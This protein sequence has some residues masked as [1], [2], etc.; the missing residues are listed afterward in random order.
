MKETVKSKL[1]RYNYAY[2]EKEHSLDINLG[3]SQYLIVD[4][5]REG[6][7]TFK[8]KLRGWNFITGFFDTNY[9]TAVLYQT[10]GLFFAVIL[11]IVLSS[12][13]ENVKFPFVFLL[14]GM[15]AWIIIW[16]FYYLIKL[17]NMKK[18]IIFWIENNCN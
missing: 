9:K 12:Y 13:S 8:D 18:Q 17:E 7:V 11:M 2:S 3:F 16:S 10:I 14:T 1:E 15:S 6:K 4:F 5:A